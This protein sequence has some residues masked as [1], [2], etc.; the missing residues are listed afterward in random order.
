MYT[1]D[2]SWRF[3][4]THRRLPK[5]APTR[6]RR[7]TKTR[8]ISQAQATRSVT[9]PRRASPDI[10]SPASFT[11][12]LPPNYGVLGEDETRHFEGGEKDN[13]SFNQAAFH[14]VSQAKQDWLAFV[15]ENC[16][17]PNDGDSLSD[18]CFTFS[19]CGIWELCGWKIRCKAT[20]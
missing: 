1:S 3:P 14:H 18:G 19:W 13:P 4:L 11:S 6:W 15:L 17:E 10:P 5:P 16:Q 20:V 12:S 2:P 7:F 8:L 9:F